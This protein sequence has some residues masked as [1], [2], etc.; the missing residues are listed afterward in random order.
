MVINVLVFDAAGQIATPDTAAEWTDV[1]GLEE[2]VIL[3]DISGEW[4]TSWG[5]DG[6]RSQ[7]SYTILDAEGKVS[8]KQ[9]DGNGGSM[10]E[11]IDELDAA[12]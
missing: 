11:I 3:A 7:H 4:M 2:F 12:R 6:G 10:G 1:L 9:H 8:W 5:G